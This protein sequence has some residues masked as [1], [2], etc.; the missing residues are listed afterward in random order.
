[1]TLTTLTT[2]TKKSKKKKEEISRGQLSK[3][4]IIQRIR[5]IH[6]CQQVD[7]SSSFDKCIKIRS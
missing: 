1:M 4:G 2:L 3:P 7:V 5:T 6:M